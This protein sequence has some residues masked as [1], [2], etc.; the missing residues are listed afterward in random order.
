MQRQPRYH[1]WMPNFLRL[2]GFSDCSPGL[3]EIERHDQDTLALVLATDTMQA[4]TD[5]LSGQSDRLKQS[6]AGNK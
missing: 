2:F 5:L 1:Q 3:T 4:E 6:L